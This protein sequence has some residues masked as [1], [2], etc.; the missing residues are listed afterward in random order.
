MYTD[1]RT[2]IFQ[3]KLSSFRRHFPHVLLRVSV[4]TRRRRNCAGALVKVAL[5]CITLLYVT[6]AYSGQT[7]ICTIRA[8]YA[9]VRDTF[10]HTVFRNSISEQDKT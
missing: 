4:R 10:V 8:V 2:E 5:H 9:H 7:I 3:K 1:R 6:Y